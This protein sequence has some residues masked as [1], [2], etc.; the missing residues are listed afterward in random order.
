MPI[1][2]NPEDYTMPPPRPQRHIDD[3]NWIIESINE[4]TEKY[5][6]MWIAVLDKE[7]VIASK[8][9]GKV[10]TMA[11]KKAREVGR[12]P[13]FYKFVESLQRLRRSPK[14]YDYS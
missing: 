1:V 2:K 14:V 6:D 5:P 4:L 8:D 11:R 12:G 13:C 9:L 3:S 10:K 7:V